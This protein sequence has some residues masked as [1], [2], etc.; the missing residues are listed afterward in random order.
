M[1][2]VA[3]ALL[4]AFVMLPL[5]GLIGVIKTLMSSSIFAAPSSPSPRRNPQ[6]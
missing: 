1:R 3:F 5:V 4:A 2:L 6:E